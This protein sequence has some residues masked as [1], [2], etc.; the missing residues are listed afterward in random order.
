MSRFSRE[1]SRQMLC[2]FSVWKVRRPQ[3]QMGSSQRKRKL[4]ALKGLVAVQSFFAGSE[5]VERQVMGHL[6]AERRRRLDGVSVRPHQGKSTHQTSHLSWQTSCVGPTCPWPGLF[7]SV[8]GNAC[9]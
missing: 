3:F 5:F 7:S 6:H 1:L 2:A 9:R 8:G 4:H